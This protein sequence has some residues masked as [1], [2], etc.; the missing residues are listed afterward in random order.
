MVSPCQLCHHL[1]SFLLSKALVASG[2]GF[3]TMAHTVSPLVPS[4]QILS[5]HHQADICVLSRE[6]EE[7]WSL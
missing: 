1:L 3:E 5:L 4:P 7:R 6:G 2:L